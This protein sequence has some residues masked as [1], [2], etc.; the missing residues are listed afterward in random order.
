MHR[1][2]KDILRRVRALLQGSALRVYGLAVWLAASA[3]PRLHYNPHATWIFIACL[4][5]GG[6]TAIAKMLASGTKSTT[7]TPS[8]EGHWLVPH[9]CA[10][11]RRWDPNLA[12]NWSLV[13][14]VW[15]SCL[16]KFKAPFIVVEKSPPNL[17]RFDSLISTFEDMPHV[18]IV[19]ARHPLAVCAS[20]ARRYRPETIIRSWHPE[21]Q[22]C[23]IETNDLLFHET[24]GQICG[25]RLEMLQ[26]IS[27][28]ATLC[29][30]YEEVAVDPKAFL[31]QLCTQVPLLADVDPNT[32]L[33]VKDY[34]DQKFLNLNDQDIARLTPN[35]RDAVVKGLASYGS[36]V[37]HFSYQL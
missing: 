8:G 31:A 7:L 28:T 5:N 11:G 2:N 22:G 26:E 36:A 20:W 6:S 19:M 15:L 13:R 18:S 4:P 12:I 27:K 1:L 21:L 9:M 33:K 37:A 25:K 34:P 3:L 14:K 35:Q 16:I 23:G 17:C 30:T 29:T 32:A 10:N 24:L